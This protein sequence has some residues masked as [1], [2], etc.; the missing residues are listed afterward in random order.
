M[1][2]KEPQITFLTHFDSY[3][4]DFSISVDKRRDF[5]ITGGHAGNF[6]YPSKRT[7]ILDIKTLEQ[8]E[9]PKLN[10][11]R[12]NHTSLILN[13]CLFVMGGI[14]NYEEILGSIEC[15]SIAK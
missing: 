2:S 13:S 10:Q 15:L 3:V 9:L 5:Y 6:N 7:F 11:G 14:A 1:S 12:H 4:Q 8:R